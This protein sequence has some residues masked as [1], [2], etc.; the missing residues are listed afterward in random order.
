M[1][2]RPQKIVHIRLIFISFL[3]LLCVMYT[4]SFGE[5]D[6]PTD[7]S[8]V[9]GSKIGGLS[10]TNLSPATQLQ[11]VYAARQG[12]GLKVFVGAD[13]MIENYKA[14][15]IEDP[16]QIVFDLFNIKSPYDNEKV[17]PVNTEWVNQIRYASESDKVRVILETQKKHLDG[18]RADPVENGLL[19][20]V[21]TGADQLAMKP[22]AVPQASPPETKDGTKGDAKDNIPA[23]KKSDTKLARGSR[24]AG[25]NQIDF[26]GAGAGK[27]VLVVGTTRPVKYEAKKIGD[28]RLEIQLFDTKLP[29]YRERPLITDRFESAVDEIIQKTKPSS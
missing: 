2:C 9:D 24:P 22:A 21:G 25:I 1:K 15:T 12:K 13:G 5:T 27:S 6:A 10:E 19:I 16:P 18:Y 11:S 29:E 3:V 8:Q 28:S 20:Q 17:I 23:E 26:I 14:F 4:Q 7:G